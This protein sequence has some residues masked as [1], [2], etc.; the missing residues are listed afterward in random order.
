[1]KE[2]KNIVIVNA[3]WNNRGDEAALRAVIK[4]IKAKFAESS[5]TILFKDGKSIEQFPYHDIKYVE[6]KFRTPIWNIWFTVLFKGLLG[7]NKT[8]KNIVRVLNKADLIVYSPGGSVINKRFWWI[9]QMEYL[10]PFICSRIYSIPMV[11][12]APS[13][14]PFNLD[15]KNRLLNWLLTAPKVFCVREELSAKY[16]N[17]IG[18]KKNV[19]VTIDSAFYDEV[20][21]NENQT[22]LENYKELGEFL[23]TYKKVIGITITDF[24]WHVKYCKDEFLSQNIRQSFTQFIELLNI[25]G[26]GVLFIPQLFGN[27]NDVDYMNGFSRKNTFTLSPDF[28]TYFQQYIISKLHAVV[29]MRY[30]SNIFSAKMGIPFIAIVYEEKMQGFIQLAGLDELAIDLNDLNFNNLIDKFTLLES[31]YNSIR[32]NLTSSLPEWQKL[33]EQTINL[34]TNFEK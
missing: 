10:T 9:K 2:V 15:K 18:I 33:A 4:G 13:I 34:I 19:Y 22:K 12:A 26:Y 32:K 7:I 20:D 14:G 30:H 16:L 25:R 31:N 8:L 17:E 6:S 11:V 21:K 5:I 1:M 24:A 27:Q 23:N 28:D 3:H 29:G